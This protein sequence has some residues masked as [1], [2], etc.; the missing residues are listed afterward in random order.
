[1]DAPVRTFPIVFA[2]DGNFSVPLA[3][4]V[5]SMLQSARP[6]TRY[7]IHVLDDGVLDFAKQHIETLHDRYAFAITYHSVSDLVLG[8]SS[9][10]YFP[11]VSFARFMIPELLGDV[12]GSRI[13]YSDADVLILDDL[14]PLFEMDMEG[15]T[16][17]GIQELAVLV[18]SDQKHLNG[19]KKLFGFAESD[20]VLYCNSG[21]LVFDKQRWIEKGYAHEIMRISREQRG[22]Q[23]IFPDQ[24][25]MNFVCQGD[26]ALLPPKFCAIPMYADIY[27]GN[28]AE[29]H[30][31][32]ECR[33]AAAELRQAAQHPALIHFAGRKPRVLEGARYPLEQPFIDF[34]K[35]SVWQDYMPYSPRI[36]SFSPSRFIKQNTPISSQLNILRKEL[37]KYSVASFMPLPKRRHYAE[38]RKGIRLVLENAR[39]GDPRSSS[40]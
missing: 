11:R 27:A 32:T 9:T 22:G 40:Q 4:A 24:D 13:F 36:G 30:F 10:H 16:L 25:I 14:T 37:L 34:W 15:K 23:A 19:W 3:I 38:Q 2:A 21:N 8:V 6:E 18:E 31:Q 28:D 33:Y 35:K 29:A 26:I 7:D 20:N 1:M 17:G 39:S 12:S 5:E